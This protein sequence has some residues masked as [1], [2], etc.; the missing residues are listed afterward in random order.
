MRPKTLAAAI[1]PPLVSL[2]YARSENF[3]VSLIILNCV[4]LALFLQ[5]ATNFYNDGIDKIK[6]A[7][8]ERVG[9]QR[10]GGQHKIEPK[11]L[12]RIGH[13]FIALAFLVAIPIFLKGGL[14]YLLLGFLSAFLAYGYTGGPYPLAYLGLGELF[15]F[16][17]FGL[18]ATVGSFH[19]TTG[20]LDKNIFIIGSLIGLLSTT[21][22]AINN[23]RDRDLDK[24]VGKRTLATRISKDSYLKLM[25]V[26][27]FLPFVITLY[28]IIK[29]KLSYLILLLIA[30]AAHRIRHLVRNYQ[31]PDEL[32]I[33]LGLA[34]KQLVLFAVLFWLGSLWQ[35][36]M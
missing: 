15:V 5:I 4:L 20:E 14:I 8:E 1:V 16:I 12:M 23:F 9:P 36:A 7:D 3:E 32:N 28:L 6:G 18:V 25:D 29:V 33:G 13:S 30:G 27:L 21:L 11:V 10:L 19:I 2:C 22:I 35:P 26:F 17:F 31:H 24:K 34:G